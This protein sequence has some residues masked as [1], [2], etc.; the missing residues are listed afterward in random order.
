MVTI[1]SY[2]EANYGVAFSLT[3]VHPSGAARSSVGQSFTGLANYL[4]KTCRFY[5]SKVG[6]PVGNLVAVLSTHSGTYGTDSV[7]TGAALATSNPIAIAGLGAIALVTFT[8]PT[9]YKLAAV[10]YC[11]DVRVN[12]AVTINGVT[13]YVPV[14]QDSS[15]PSHGGNYFMYQSGAWSGD[16]TRDTCF[17]GDG[18]LSQ[19]KGS[20][21]AS[22]I[23]CMRS[24]QNR[25]P[26]F[27]PRMVI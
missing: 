17:Y 13:D 12:D 16:N 25:L 4:L 18:T 2:S 22:R 15:A 10:K 9:P 3:A 5:L 11:L 24:F 14:G 8:F 1:D 7:P 20:N 19:I 23:P 6:V 26:K 21:V 27:Q